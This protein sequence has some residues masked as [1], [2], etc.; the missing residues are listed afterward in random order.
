MSV[1]GEWIKIRGA[2]T[3]NLHSLTAEIPLGALTVITGPSGSGKS[4]LAFD[5]LF[6]EGRRRYLETL[7]GDKRALFRELQRPDVDAIEGLP[8]VVCVSQNAVQTRPRSTLATVTEI[9]DHLRLLFAR[10]GVRYCPTCNLPIYKHT[11][12]EIISA[13]LQQDG[14]KIFVMAPLVLNQPGDHKEQFRR[15]IQTGFLRARVDGVLIEIRDVPKLD[16]KKPHTIEMI[17]DRLVVKPTIE[18]RLRESLVSAIQHSGG[19]VVI[20]DVETGDWHDDVYSTQYACAVCGATAPDLEPRD[21]HFNNPHG[22]CPRCTGFGQIAMGDASAKPQAD[23]VDSDSTDDTPPADLIDFV[24]CPDCGGARLNRQARAVRFADKGLHEITAMSVD[25][26]VSFFG[27]IGGGDAPSPPA[28]LPR[29]GEGRNAA[30]QLL[31]G[32]ITQRLRFLQQVGLGYLTLDRPAPTLSGGEAQRARLATHLGGGLLGVCY[33]LD[34]PTMGLHPRDTQKLLAALRGLQGHGNTVIVVEHDET[35]IRAAD[36][37]IDIGPGAGRHGGRLLAC[38]PV[39]EVLANPDSVTGKALMNFV[40][41][42]SP[43]RATAAAIGSGDLR[44]SPVVDL[45]SSPVARSGDRATKTAITV[46][47]RS[48]D[49]ASTTEWLTIHCARHHNLK[50]ITA[51]FPLGR[52]TCLTGVSGSGKS[53]LARDI[54][55][56]AARRHLG[57]LA[58]TPGA[59]DRIDGL[60]Q[61][62]KVL[63]VDQHPIG[64]SSRSNP[65]SYVGVYDEIRK[66][67]AATKLAKIRG[68]KANRFS[69]NVKGGR[70]EECEGHGSVGVDVAFMPDLRVPCPVCQGKRFNPATLQVRYKGLSIADVLELPIEDARAFFANVPTVQP[71][72]R[73]LD[74]VGLGYLALGQ[75]ANTLSGGEAQRVKLAAELG[76]TSTGKTLYLFDEPTTGLHFVDITRLIGVFRK[77]VDAGNTLIVIEHHPALIRAADWVIDLGPEAGDEGGEIVIAGTPAEVAGCERSLTGKDL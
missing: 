3:H 72:L 32:E 4:S 55:M 28:P 68:F 16:A 1:S 19:R 21:F 62:D 30:R 74:E 65:A 44:S 35:V 26:A 2:R 45:R 15:I 46:V 60:D 59:H 77:L 12:S 41:A 22:A 51:A 64:K 6:A 75:P 69:F 23:D 52:W 73:A 29:R 56:H 57:L 66:I 70:C 54:L 31:L 76:K 47:A 58:P 53:S 9:H 8:P 42:R 34:E 67:F 48:P 33:I 25:D 17:V 18:D 5:T 71:G 38:G 20:T 7:R 36:W 43:D 39:A 24:P 63:E 11:L 49:R 40:V 61:I 13:T 14:R 50:N 10:F 37:L 27:Q